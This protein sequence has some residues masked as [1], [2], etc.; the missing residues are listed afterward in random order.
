MYE[1][2]CRNLQPLFK[3]KPHLLE[4]S[5]LNLTQTA[6]KVISFFNEKIIHLTEFLI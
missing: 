5:S 1:Q 3:P 6:G 2:Y 4:N